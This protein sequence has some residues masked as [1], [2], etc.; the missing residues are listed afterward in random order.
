MRLSRHT[1]SRVLV[2]SM[3]SAE[4]LPWVSFY[5]LTKYLHEED[6]HHAHGVLGLAGQRFGLHMLTTTP[7]CRDIYE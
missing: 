6:I 3:Y 4:G 7:K 1:E 2:L 5:R